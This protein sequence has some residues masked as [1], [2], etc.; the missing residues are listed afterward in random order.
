MPRGV[1]EK[2]ASARPQRGYFAMFPLTP[3]FLAGLKI[4][5]DV[6]YVSRIELQNWEKPLIFSNLA[7]SIKLAQCFFPLTFININFKCLI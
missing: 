1:I 5:D 4:V 3:V 7:L 6:A 2:R